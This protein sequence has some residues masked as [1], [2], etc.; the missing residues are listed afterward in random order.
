MNRPTVEILIPTFNRPAALAVT[1]AS[2]ASQLFRDFN[3]IVA[4]Q[5]DHEVVSYPEVRAMVRVL[6]EH[7]NTVA[8]YRRT[9]RQGIGEQRQFLL[10]QSSAH[11]IAFLDDDLFLE[12][13]VITNMH[14]ALGEENIGFVGCAVIGLSY[15]HD[16]RPE[17]QFIE[18]WQGPVQP[19]EVSP[20]KPAWQRYQLHNAANL[21]HVQQKLGLTAEEPL[22]YK[23][24]WTGGCVMYDA[25]K[26]RSVGGFTFWSD[27]PANAIGEDV[28]AQLR[29]MRAY[30]GC[31]LIPS[32][33]YHQEL[34]TTLPDRSIDAPKIL[35]TVEDSS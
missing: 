25:E 11:H 6:E 1:L 18:F 27:L 13:Y 24:A 34:P 9:T 29:V 12:P 22:R 31:G 7:G 19:E 8:I 28:L 15:L 4:D 35:S 33:V 32:G 3:V 20:D 26:L 23:I 5:S 16:V 10:E 17:Q 21:Y 14:T 30:G 2:L